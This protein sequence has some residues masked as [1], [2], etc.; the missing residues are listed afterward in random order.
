VGFAAGG[1]GG[2][3]P[4]HA[5]IFKAFQEQGVNFDILGGASAGA[6]VLAG[7]A[8]LLSPADIDRALE[9]IF[10]TS[11][12]FKYRTFPRYSLLDH[13]AFDKAL[14]R[15]FRDA[16]IE[17]LW[18]PFFAVA[19][20]VDRA[21]EGLYLMR[22]GPLWKAVRASCSIPAVLPPMFPDDSR[23]L[24]DGGIV[25]NIPLAPMKSLKSGPN[26]VVHFGMPPVR[27]HTVKYERHPRPLAI[28]GQDAQPPRAGQTARCAWADFRS[29]A[30]FMSAP[31]SRSA[32]HRAFRPCAG[33]AAV[34][35]FKLPRF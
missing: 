30:V 7:F 26:L 32:S 11:R 19:A 33:S 20:D 10:V 25:D 31:E 24:V 29:A 22:R 5:G 34:P 18:V 6:A 8:L 12:G 35:G 23:M 4:A 14:Q 21:G 28:A 13:V 15:Q 27:R 3:G 2:F 17:D 1:G 9:D 16:H